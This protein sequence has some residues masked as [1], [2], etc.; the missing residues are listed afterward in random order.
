VIFTS[1]DAEGL[2]GCD[3]GARLLPPELLPHAASS[4]ED[5]ATAGMNFV[6]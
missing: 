4:K 3:A 5:T 2:L 6:N 1:A